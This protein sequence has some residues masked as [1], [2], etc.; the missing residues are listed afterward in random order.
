MEI[1]RIEY[2]LKSYFRARLS[3]IEKYAVYYQH[4]IE[5][6]A[7]KAN[8]DESNLTEIQ[9]DF[10]ER[11]DE[12]EGKFLKDIATTDLILHSNQISKHLPE[13]LAKWKSDKFISDCWPSPNENAFCF[14]RVVG[15]EGEAGDLE[16][17]DPTTADERIERA[18]R[19]NVYW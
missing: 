19:G 1:F 18:V 10:Y 12:D 15:G 16:I 13:E 7:E 17:L 5:L 3:K 6:I 9:K 14:G 2:M 4:M 11:F 8:S